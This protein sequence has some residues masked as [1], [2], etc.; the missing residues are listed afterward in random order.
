MR[1]L[2]GG[3]RRSGTLSSSPWQRS[4]T[5]HF[6]TSARRLASSFADALGVG[7][8]LRGHRGVVA[9]DHLTRAR[10]DGL[11][12]IRVREPRVY[13][14]QLRGLARRNSGQ[15]ETHQLVLDLVEQHQRCWHASACVAEVVLPDVQ[16]V[17]PPQVDHA[18]VLSG[19]GD[20]LVPFDVEGK[21]QR[22][23]SARP[24]QKVGIDEVGQLRRVQ[25]LVE[26]VRRGEEGVRLLLGDPPAPPRPARAPCRADV[27]SVGRTLAQRALARGRRSRHRAA[28]ASAAVVSA[29]CDRLRR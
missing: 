17:E 29:A 26:R 5:C 7:A 6:S 24:R 12:S 23:R 8:Q 9:A 19:H 27:P 25:R 11:D 16:R 14:E 20:A 13:V 4:V 2:C 18:D 3:I 22:S 15:G 28:R 21:Q 1:V 10:L